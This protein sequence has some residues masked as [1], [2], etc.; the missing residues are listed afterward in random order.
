MLAVLLESKP[1]TRRWTRGASL[2]VVAHVA[3]I[4]AVVAGTAHGTT[5]GSKP[6][7][8][9]AVHIVP[10]P[11]PHQVRS[12]PHASAR[13]AAPAL[14]TDILI[15]HVDAPRIVP[16]T[17]PP[18]DLSRGSANDSIVI[19]GGSANHVGSMADLYD[20]SGTN[21]NR[22][23]DTREILMHVLTKSA[24]PYPEAL[25]SAGVDG[26]VLVEFTVDTTGR[27]DPNSIRVVESTHELFTRAVREALAGFRFVPAQAAGRRV[28][29]LAQMPFEFHITR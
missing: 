1:R 21:D 19:G 14:R 24:P 26:H 16:T 27:V 10:P 8:V 11:P 17:L 5:T 15:R 6:E 18:I 20:A 29:A 12:E 9:V 23:W 2:S 25:R 7:K 3:I 28:S 22:N 4:G 13:S